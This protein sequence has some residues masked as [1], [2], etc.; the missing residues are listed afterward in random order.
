MGPGHSRG[1]L[2]LQLGGAVLLEHR[3][4]QLLQKSILRA[5]QLRR[6][7]QRTVEPEAQQPLGRAWPFDPL[8][9]RSGRRQQAA[10]RTFPEKWTP[11]CGTG[12]GPEVWTRCR[13]VGT[14]L[15][16]TRSSFRPPASPGSQTPR[17]GKTKSRRGNPLIRRWEGP[18][19]HLLVSASLNL[20]ER[21]LRLVQSVALRLF[22][23]PLRWRSLALRLRELS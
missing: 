11:R 13:P 22:P 17:R 19:E 7:R 8:P 3:V 23:V 5:Y 21:L 9:G 20:R 14:A 12:W 16:T 1:Y 2:H 4:R 10:P 15:S 6:E 18:A